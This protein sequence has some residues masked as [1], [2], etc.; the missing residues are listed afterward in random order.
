MRS[1]IR[2]AWL[3]KIGDIPV[4]TVAD[5]KRALLTLFE[6]PRANYMLTLSHP[7]IRHGLTNDSIPQLNVNQLNFRNMFHDFCMPEGAL[8]KPTATIRRDG[9]VYNYVTQAMKLTRGKK[10][11]KND[12][13]DIWQ[14]SEFIQ[15]D[16][17]DAQGM[18]GDPV[19]V[20]NK[21]AVFNLVWSYVV[22]ELDKRKKA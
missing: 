22:K 7:E 1:T 13:W 20:T 14:K 4:S 15:L 5:V 11:L 21:G 8:D 6:Q 9:D 10:L 12:H 16:Q 2:H 19:P 17:Y 3:R 18:F